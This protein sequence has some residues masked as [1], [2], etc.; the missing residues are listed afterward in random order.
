MQTLEVTDENKI[1]AIQSLQSDHFLNK[2][3]DIQSI[4]K[5]SSLPL[6]FG[7]NSAHPVEESKYSS[8]V[9]EIWED[10]LPLTQLMEVYN[11]KRGLGN[12]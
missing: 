10:L 1:K 9:G 11:G 5:E 8:G 3:E 4:R 6:P 7:P 2:F 12:D